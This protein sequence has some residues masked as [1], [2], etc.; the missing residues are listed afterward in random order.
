MLMPEQP[1]EPDE[2]VALD[3]AFESVC[4]DLSIGNGSLDVSNRERIL[5]SLLSLVRNGE[6]DI[7][8]LRRR[9]VLFFENTTA[10]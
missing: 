9:A 10:E 5:H 8:V 3:F 4:R 7:D 2:M 6:R 1:L